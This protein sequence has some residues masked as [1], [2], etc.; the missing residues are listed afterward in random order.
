MKWFIFIFT[1]FPLIAFSG[2]WYCHD[3][4]SSWM[5][6]GKMLQVCGIGFG[7][8]ETLARQDAFESVEKE[9]K[10][11]C[12]SQST[13]GHKMANRD[14]QRTECSIVDNKYKCYRLV[15][16]YITDRDLKEEPK[17]TP[18]VV[19]PKKVT[20]NYNTYNTYNTYNPQPI[21]IEK[22]VEKIIVKEADRAPSSKKEPQ[23]NTSPQ[24]PS[25]PPIFSRSVNGVSIYETS[26]PNN[27]GNGLHLHNPSE[28]DISTAIQR[29]KGG[30]SRIY[31]HR[32]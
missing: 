11:V 27:V 18:V 14:P 28:S 16:F 21:V 6:K 32:N 8:N 9:Y 4:A 20:N 13:C 15:N 26:D 17:S 29:A 7:E 5:E 3:V 23:G 30:V 12:N 24:M 25:S 31:I 22:V 19:E 1:I 2:E 10:N